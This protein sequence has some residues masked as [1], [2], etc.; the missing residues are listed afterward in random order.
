M[1]TLGRNKFIMQVFYFWVQISFSLK[2]IWKQTSAKAVYSFGKLAFAS[3]VFPVN[4][5]SCLPLSGNNA[6]WYLIYYWCFILT[7]L[8][9][10]WKVIHCDDHLLHIL[11][12]NALILI[13]SSILRI[14][15]KKSLIYPITNF[16]VFYTIASRF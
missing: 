15:K 16:G 14:T 9:S 7:V 3:H 10:S 1:G 8:T 2:C 11:D 12:V 13:L 4:S 5:Y 6:L